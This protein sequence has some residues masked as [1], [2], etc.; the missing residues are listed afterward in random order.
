MTHNFNL[1]SFINCFIF[2]FF[3][4]QDFY[5][6]A[7]LSQN[8]AILG[9]VII[10]GTTSTFNLK[11]KKGKKMGQGLKKGKAVELWTVLGA[12]SPLGGAVDWDCCYSKSRTE[13]LVRAC[14]R[15]R[16]GYRT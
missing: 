15:S 12:Q 5:F 4:P 8:T 6:T 13:I 14:T 16:L 3:I 2:F 7:S 11:K 10:P 1:F 9:R